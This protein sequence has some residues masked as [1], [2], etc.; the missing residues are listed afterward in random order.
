MPSSRIADDFEYSWWL[1]V[2]AAI[3]DGIISCL[4]ESISADAKRAY[5]ILV[6]E[7]QETSGSTYNRLLLRMTHG[8]NRLKLMKSFIKHQPIRVLRHYRLQL[9]HAPRGGVRYDGL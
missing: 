3:R 1:T 9:P 2:A 7:E 5:A 6:S 8:H 4:D